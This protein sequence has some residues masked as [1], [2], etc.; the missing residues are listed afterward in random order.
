MSLKYQGYVFDKFILE[1]QITTAIIQMHETTNKI[2]KES[3]IIKIE[4]SN[5]KLEIIGREVLKLK[6][7]M[8][9]AEKKSQ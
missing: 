1:N 9:L 2:L 5:E 4:N 8:M 7:T 3:N 6:E